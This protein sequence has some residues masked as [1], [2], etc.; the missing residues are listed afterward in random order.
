MN[1]FVEL[2]RLV[3]NMRSMLFAT[4]GILVTFSGASVDAATGDFTAAGILLIARE[5]GSTY[6]LLGKDRRRGWYEMLAGGRET[7]A[8]GEGGHTRRLET[9]YETALRE[10]FEESRGFLKP[11]YLLSIVNPADFLR[12]EHLVYFHAEIEK[13]PVADL[14]SMPLP[15]SG[16]VLG[17]LE[18]GDYAWVSVE[19]VLSAQDN[20]VLDDTGRRIQLRAQF[21]FRLDQARAAGWL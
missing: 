10:C 16:N 12:D 6:V 11:E 13:V 20:F 14:L 1:G 3:K 21:R 19:T 15:R 9:A 17:F 18:I 8:T 7:V 2:S 5:N 4:I